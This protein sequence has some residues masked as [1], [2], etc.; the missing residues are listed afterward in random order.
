MVPH[1]LQLATLDKA[2]AEVGV[3]IVQR[4]VL[5]ALRNRQFFSLAELNEAI[6]ELVHKLES[7]RIRV[8]GRGVD[9]RIDSWTECWVPSSE[10]VLPFL[11][12]YAGSDLEQEMGSALAP[13]HLLAFCHPLADNLIDC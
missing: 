5:A 1:N 10:C 6:L 13:P 4:W 11:I 8:S 7:G 9:L 2:K 12:E 3:Q